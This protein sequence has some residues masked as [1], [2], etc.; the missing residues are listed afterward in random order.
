[1]SYFYAVKPGSQKDAGAANIVNVTGK[2]V[3][4]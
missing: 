1:M 2:T 3:C 4:Y